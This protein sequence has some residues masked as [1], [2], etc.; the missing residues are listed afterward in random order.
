MAKIAPQ[1]ILPAIFH[2][3]A[4]DI[5]NEKCGPAVEVNNFREEKS[6]KPASEIDLESVSSDSLPKTACSCGRFH[7]KHWGY[8]WL[9]DP[10][11]DFTFA[12]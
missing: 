10:E 2:D 6:R 9:R 3:G 8:S 5:H 11:H 4:K 12:K 1:P 7:D